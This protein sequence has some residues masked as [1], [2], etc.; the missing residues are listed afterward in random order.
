MDTA[1]TTMDTARTAHSGVGDESARAAFSDDGSESCG[2]DLFPAMLEEPVKL[3]LRECSLHGDVN[4]VDEE[5]RS[6]L[7]LCPGEAFALD[8]AEEHGRPLLFCPDEP[9]SF[10]AGLC[11]EA[12]PCTQTPTTPYGRQFLFCPPERLDLD[13]VGAISDPAFCTQSCMNPVTLGNLWTNDH[14]GF[15]LDQLPAG[16]VNHSSAS[17]WPHSSSLL[18]EEE[19]ADSIVISSSQITFTA[20]ELVSSTAFP[21][22]TH[23]EP[24]PKNVGPDGDVLEAAC[25]GLGCIQMADLGAGDGDY[26]ATPSVYGEYTGHDVPCEFGSWPACVPPSPALTASPTASPKYGNRRQL[27]S[28]SDPKDVE[29]SLLFASA[30]EPADP[31]NQPSVIRLAD[32][33]Q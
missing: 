12:A 31:Y 6:R 21:A 20:S 26:K 24:V 13:N 1:R 18:A 8:E 19:C 33:L 28:F 32:L 29:G 22:H 30:I 17:H 16:A 5:P 4:G 11:L 25:Q 2:S 15:C 9:L 23:A 27:R 10:E 3:M 14:N 7:S